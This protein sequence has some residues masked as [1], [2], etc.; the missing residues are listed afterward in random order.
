[1]EAGLAFA[2]DFSKPDFIGKEAL[3][4]IR[5]NGIERKLCAITLQAGHHLFGGESVYY[6]GTLIDRIRS[7]AYGHSIN[8]DVGL[9]YL[10]LEQ[11]QPDTALEVEVLGERLPA[12][13]A[14][15]PLVTP[16]ER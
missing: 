15:L 8:A 10:P 14:K 2:V 7:T 4:G 16:A 12:R 5:D 9:V 6:R 11:C 1:M 13:V 3:E